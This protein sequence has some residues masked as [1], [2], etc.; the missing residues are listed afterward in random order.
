MKKIVFL[1]VM[2][3]VFQVLSMNVFS[4]TT[5]TKDV[6]Y[7]GTGSNL[8]GVLQ[9]NSAHN[10]FEIRGHNIPISYYIG[11]AKA[12][13]MRLGYNYIPTL[14]FPVQDN[15]ARIVAATSLSLAAGN[16]G[17]TNN[18]TDLT[19]TEAGNI[20]IGTN[21][22]NE[23]LT[24]EG[25]IR[26]NSGGKLIYANELELHTTNK[27]PI[28]FNIQD[29]KGLQIKKGVNDDFTL[30][31]PVSNNSNNKW[32]RIIA[33]NN[34]SFTAGDRGVTDSQ[35]DLFISTIGNIG[36][37]LSDPDQKLTVNGNIKLNNGKLFINVNVDSIATT[38]L[39]HF[40]A[41]ITGG[42]LSEDFAL[43]PQSEWAD[44]VFNSDY[45]LQNLNE[46]ENY[47]KA[48]NHLPNIPT[49]SEVKE[50]GYSLHNMNVKL[51]QKVEELTLYSIEQNKKIEQ[52]EKVVTSYE[53][54]LEKVNQ[55]ENKI[56]Q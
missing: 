3:C 51:L 35:T 2:A 27:Q 52:L 22:P 46:V 18:T 53:S 17:L 55:L 20:G 14:Y 12:F 19:I 24:V 48:N 26:M 44:H 37:G 42:V 40:S 6:Y 25:N 15:P 45:K 7:V 33:K 8:V 9:G 43:A 10:E 50:N 11:N 54:L 39:D 29:T 56:N 32:N 36:I 4:Q 31:F 47:I 1:T 13:Q 38:T 30:Y 21:S 41:F 23:K 16:R 28:S 5:D 49:A 34:L